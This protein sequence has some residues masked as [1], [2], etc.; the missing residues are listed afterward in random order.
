MKIKDLKEYKVK[1]IK[2]L[3]KA[4]VEK[5]VELIKAVAAI[6]AGKEKNIKKAAGI[7]HTLAQLK[8][9]VR[10]KQLIKEETK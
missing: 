4:M 3:N 10:E 2:E 9:I 8:T 5:E 7:R 6:R 1:E